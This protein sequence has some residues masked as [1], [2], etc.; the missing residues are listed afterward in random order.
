LTIGGEPANPAPFRLIDDVTFGA[1]V[2]V[3]AFTN[4]YGCRIGDET[5]IGPFVEIQRDAVIGARCKIQ[6]HS[7]IC[8]G[9]NIEDEVF[10]GHGSL[11]IN[12][13]FPRAT[14][15][16]GALKTQADWT[17][18]RTVVERGA[19]LGSGVVVLGG[20]RI[21]AGALV[22]AGAVVTCDVAPRETV[23]GVPARARGS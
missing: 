5:R 2:V 15:E 21:G 22:G 16:S 18:L 14:T 4:L 7:F 1:D 17:L 23:I 6:S 13:K 9:V 11:F 8:S 12:D 3:A 10:V 20:V 19:A